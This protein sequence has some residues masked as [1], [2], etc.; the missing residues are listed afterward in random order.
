M[1]AGDGYGVVFGGSKSRIDFSSDFLPPDGPS[2]LHIPD[3][4][5]LCGS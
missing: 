3:L 4:L 1:D 5:D 2:N